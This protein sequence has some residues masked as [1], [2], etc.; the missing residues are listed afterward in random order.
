MNGYEFTFITKDGSKTVLDGAE[1][2]ITDFKG[3]VSAKDD[4]GRKPIAYKIAGLKE[5][6]YHVWA[7]DMSPSDMLEFKNKLNLEKGV[8]R[9]LILN[10]D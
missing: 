5:G 2:L 10:Q 7:V 6:H 8:I 9:Y 3:K 1:K 4:W